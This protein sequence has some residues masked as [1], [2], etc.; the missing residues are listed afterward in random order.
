MRSNLIL[1]SLLYRFAAEELKA[2]KGEMDVTKQD[3]MGL[4]QQIKVLDDAVISH[5]NAAA[6]A[7]EEVQK[8]AATQQVVVH[9]LLAATVELR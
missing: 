9:Y 5:K 1:S 8:L 7:V 6:H 3:R 4:V 2:L